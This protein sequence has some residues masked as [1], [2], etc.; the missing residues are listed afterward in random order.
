MAEMASMRSCEGGG[1]G[2]PEGNG[3][4]GSSCVSVRGVLLRGMVV[5]VRQGSTHGKPGI[6]R[7]RV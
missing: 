4:N 6:S 5:V 2:R 3:S 1:G 7:T